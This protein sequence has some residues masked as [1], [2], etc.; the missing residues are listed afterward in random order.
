MLRL[1]TYEHGMIA[2]EA[3]YFRLVA[4]RVPDVPTPRVLHHGDGWLFT[5]HMPGRPLTADPA[6]DHGGVREQ[7]GAALA[8]VHRVTGDHFGYPGPRPQAVLAD[9]EGNGFCVERSLSERA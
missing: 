3:A 8:R 1:L 7:L 2:C 6:A 5:T 4:D 9:P